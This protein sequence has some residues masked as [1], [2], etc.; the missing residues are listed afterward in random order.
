MIR[1]VV[2]GAALGLALVPAAA[3]ADRIPVGP[4]VYR[5]L[6]PAGKGDAAIAVRRFRLDETPV[7]NAEYLAFVQ[8]EPRWRRDRVGSLFADDGYLARWQDA[9]T[10]GDAAPADAPVVEVSWFAARAY[11]A[12]RGGRLPREHE[13]ELAAAASAT[14]RDASGDPAHA[15]QILAWYAKPTP[16]VLPAVGGA[17]NAWGVRDL[18]GLVWEWIEDFSAAL[19]VGDDRGRA[20]AGKLFCGG[21]AQSSSDPTAYAAFMRIAYRSSLEARY[22]TPSLG[23]RCAYDARRAP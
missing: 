14:E 22:S 10:P 9:T 17:A 15:A 2:I 20:A 13:W 11:C 7:T 19:V 23:F 8:A 16:P 18:H 1:G 21:A 6:F 12:W 5:P 4:G 3:A